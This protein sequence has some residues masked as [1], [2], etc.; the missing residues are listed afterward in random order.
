MQNNVQSPGRYRDRTVEYAGV[1]GENLEIP[2][3]NPIN[4]YEAINASD[5]IEKVII[6]GK[7]FV[8]SEKEL[9]P[10][11]IIVPGSLGVGPN[12]E[13]HAETLVSEGYAVF[14]LDP[15]GARSV[16]ST[17]ENQTQYSFAAV[18]YTHLTLPTIYSV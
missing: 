12:H 7:L 11:V 16:E 6:D 4:Y 3:A 2:S 17:V 14:V 13:A 1:V 9:N 5:E 15:F 18:S 10:L 8:S